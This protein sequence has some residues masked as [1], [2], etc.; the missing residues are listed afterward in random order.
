IVLHLVF[1]AGE[2]D[3]DAEPARVAIAQAGPADADA[4]TAAAV[5]EAL[6]GIDSVAVQ[7]A[8]DP[9]AEVDAG[10]ADLAVLHD[11]PRAE[12]VRGDAS[13]VTTRLVAGVTREVLEGIRAAGVAAAA[14][15]DL[16][17][18]PTGTGAVATASFDLR[19]GQAADTQLDV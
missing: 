16:A 5:T 18:D 4:Q 2:T 13:Q 19:P 14:A 7:P 17:L 12:L 8:A 11:G 9:R 10:R 1:T 15:G 6:G 3:S